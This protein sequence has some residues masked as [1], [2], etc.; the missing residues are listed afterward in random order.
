MAL[1]GEETPGLGPPFL[2]SVPERQQGLAASGGVA[3]PGD[4]QNVLR[5]EVLATRTRWLGERAVGARVAT[6]RGDRDEHLR[7]EGDGAAPA[8][9][10]EAPGVVE[11]RSGIAQPV[12]VLDGELSV[13]RRVTHWL[14]I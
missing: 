8:L 9:V 11:E 14:G 12:E 3:G 13:S 10:P 4:R 2:R 5:R 6:E 7:A 1:G